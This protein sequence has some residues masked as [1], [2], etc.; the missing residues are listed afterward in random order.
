MQRLVETTI[1]LFVH[2]NYSMLQLLKSGPDVMYVDLIV[3]FENEK[4]EEV[5]GPPVRY[6]IR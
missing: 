3:S 1:D 6:T 2:L 4:G 5:P